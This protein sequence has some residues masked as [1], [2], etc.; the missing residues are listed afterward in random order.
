MVHFNEMKKILKNTKNIVKFTRSF[1][2]TQ[3]FFVRHKK[4]KTLIILMVH[5]AEQNSRNEI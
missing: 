2:R 1:E 4:D 3:S 5:L